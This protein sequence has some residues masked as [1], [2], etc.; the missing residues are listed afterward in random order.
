M[1]T[2]GSNSSTLMKD[3]FSAGTTSGE[4]ERACYPLSP[5]MPSTSG[6]TLLTARALEILT[7]LEHCPLTAAQLLKFSQTFSHPF[8]DE[9]RVRER[10]QALAAAGRV[11]QFR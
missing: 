3:F 11:K 9:R 6:Q 5:R 7:C 8:T 1:V 10:L 4:D 2:C